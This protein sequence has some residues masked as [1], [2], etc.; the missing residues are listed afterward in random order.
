[1]VG[2]GGG[3]S[4]ERLGGLCQDAGVRLLIGPLP[5]FAAL[6]VGQTASH[7]GSPVGNGPED[8]PSMELLAPSDTVPCGPLGIRDKK[9]EA[10][11]GEALRRHGDRDEMR[12]L[13]L[14]I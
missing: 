5:G 12:G 10:G 7:N 9:G 2:G 3:H 14:G 6:V 8:F 11:R 4:A 13:G 1:M